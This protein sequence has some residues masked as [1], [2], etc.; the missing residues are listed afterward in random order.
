MEKKKKAEKGRVAVHL[1]DDEHV[2]AFDDALL[3]FGSH[4]LADLMLV[5]VAEGGV[6][7]PVAGGDGGLHRT[8]DHVAAGEVGGL[9]RVRHF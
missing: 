7:V 8:L 9:Q 3:Y 6:D 1:T 2:L 4:G 5:F